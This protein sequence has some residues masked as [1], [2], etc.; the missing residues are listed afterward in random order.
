[1][2]V[3]IDV[4][5]TMTVSADSQLEAFALSRWAKEYFDAVG[6]PRSGPCLV[7]DASDCSYITAKMQRELSA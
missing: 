6:V 3:D 2:R 4:H 1:M 7:I 5:G